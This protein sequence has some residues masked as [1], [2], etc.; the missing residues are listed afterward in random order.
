MK[1]PG[2]IAII[3]EGGCKARLVAVPN[4]WLQL[5]FE[6]LHR[7][8]DQLVQ[9]ISN[10]ASH[11]QN[12]GAYFIKSG[13][14]EG[15][16]LYGFDLSSATDRFPLYLQQQVLKGLGL[17]VFSDALSKVCHNWI[18]PVE[19]DERWNYTVGQPMGLYGSFPLF[20]LTHLILLEVLTELS[21]ADP[22]C[23]LVLGDDVI[24][25]NLDVARRY[26]TALFKLGVEVSA[27]KTLTSSLVSE[28]AGFLGI[29][30]K[31]SATVFR[32]Y[33][34][35]DLKT[36]VHSPVNLIYSMGRMV[37]TLGPFW[38]GKFEQFTNTLGWRNPD[39]SPLISNDEEA[40]G[41]QPA[42]FDLP[43]LENL[44]G[45]I[46]NGSSLMTTSGDWDDPEVDI[47]TY[48]CNGG[49]TQLEGFCRQLL[50]KQKETKVDD[51]WIPTDLLSTPEKEED[52]KLASTESKIESDPLL[53]KVLPSY[54]QYF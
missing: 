26:Q 29:K 24:I 22:Q 40:V 23:Y 13:L 6:P 51:D 8:L 19:G 50:N 47:F 18:S 15:K 35:K 43:R 17:S 32:P 3:Q 33:K 46:L 9:S 54:T 45:T 2:R 20:H 10:S 44:I 38:C 36:G 21:N 27:A 37:K 4:A 30:T 34:Y 41:V 11:D 12:R 25:N 14:E 42:V 53:G 39:L 7:S 49:E 52:E 16:T 48:I 1:T 28:F 31:G 5:F